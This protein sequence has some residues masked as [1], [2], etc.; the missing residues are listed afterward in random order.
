MEQWGW[1]HPIRRRCDAGVIG[2]FYIAP[3][4]RGDGSLCGSENERQ[5]LGRPGADPRA[6]AARRCWCSPS[7]AGG[8]LAF[9]AYSA[10]T[11]RNICSTPPASP[12][13]QATLTATGALFLFMILQ[14]V[15]GAL[16]DRIGRRPLLIAFGIGG[17][18]LTVP[19]LHGD[20]RGARGE[21][22]AASCLSSP[23]K[24]VIVY[25]ATS[26]INAISEGRA[27]PAAYPRPRRGPA[28]MP[29]PTRCSAARAGSPVALWLVKIGA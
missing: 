6:S 7:T 4:D 16:S 11:C 29:S 17:T 26:S 28:L 22:M 2:V 15:F 24:L 13:P 18:L 27:V 10:R 14:P 19:A 23:V 12:R 9:Y 3:Q 21:G 25:K 1:R 5:A 20:W 8:T